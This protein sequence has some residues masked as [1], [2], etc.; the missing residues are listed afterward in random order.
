MSMA[1]P[2]G[3]NS[4]RYETPVLRRNGLPVASVIATGSPVIPRSCSVQERQHLPRSFSSFAGRYQ[5]DHKAGGS[6]AARPDTGF[7]EVTP[8]N[9]TSEAVSSFR[10]FSRASTMTLGSEML[11]KAHSSMVLSNASQVQRSQSTNPRSASSQSFN[12]AIR[13]RSP[14]PQK[15]RSFAFSK[16]G[17]SASVPPSGWQSPRQ[18]AMGPGT[19]H[20]AQFRS[21]KQNG[22][23]GAKTCGFGGIGSAL[24]HALG[25]YPQTKGRPVATPG[26]A[27]IARVANMANLGSRLPMQ[28]TR[29]RP[30]VK[31][32][33]FRPE[34]PNLQEE[35]APEFSEPSA[36]LDALLRFIDG[37]K[38][39]GLSFTEAWYSV[40]AWT[41]YGLIHLKHHGFILAIEGGKTWLTLDFSTRGILWD[42]FDEFPDFPDGLLFH[43]KYSCNIAPEE[44]W[45]YC[46]DTRPFSWPDND[47]SK[48]ALGILEMIGIHE[49]PYVDDG[50]T[51]SVSAV[52]VITC[53]GRSNL[54]PMAVIGC[55]SA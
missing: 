10:P 42:T 16:P 19:P 27:A 17:G 25:G 9:G 46:K 28:V 23:V 31:A 14:E 4:P 37:V 15:L 8:T 2:G 51:T 41:L 53:G 38:K 24:G 18:R 52:D 21:V 20:A 40:N 47:C 12:V 34:D 44:L 54:G 32:P 11:P 5:L 39:A 35:D 22:P 36:D 3:S 33:S 13:V 1:V 55:L 49:S 45:Q 26:A 50:S 7:E 30:S 43:K 48:W 29:S 6:I